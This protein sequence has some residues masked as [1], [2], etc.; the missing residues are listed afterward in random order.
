[1]KVHIQNGVQGKYNQDLA[2]FFVPE[3]NEKPAIKQID[4][5]IGDIASTLFKQGLI[6]TKHSA[7]FVAP[8]FGKTAS[9]LV[10]FVGLGKAE[11]YTLEKVRIIGGTIAKQAKAHKVSSVAIDFDAVCAEL[12]QIKAAR[13]LTE[14]LLLGN[15]EYKEYKSEPEDDKPVELAECLLITNKKMTDALEHAVVQGSLEAEATCFARD[16]VNHPPA[17]IHPKTLKEAAEKIATESRGAITTKSYGRE[18]LTK[19]G[20]GAILGVAQGSEHE[21]FLV[22][23]EYHPKGAKKS[24]ALVG[25]GVTFDS[26]GLS[27]KPS[28]GM[29]DMKMDMAGAAAVLGVFEALKKWKPA[30]HVHG[31]FAT[32]ENM[33]SDHALRVGDIIKTMS[34]KTV[35]VLNTDAEG[36]LILADALHYADSLKTEYII[37]FATLTGACMVAL[38]HQIAGLLTKNEQLRDDLLRISKITGEKLCELPLTEEYEDEIK[39]DVADLQNMPKGRYGGAIIAGLF[40]QHFVKH[41]PWAHIDIA[42]PAFSRTACNAY[43]PAGAS[44]FGVRT[45]LH[46][47][48]QL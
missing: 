3:G 11:D 44:G 32:V 28:E 45:T 16:L 30:V 21:P 26:G 12:D 23:M 25:K 7:M 10:G 34:G 47:L 14:G 9:N 42:G 4:A 41:T 38:G 31:V 17:H 22:H 2:V 18:A 40:L 39:S 19:M 36:R 8:T 15:Y 24:V 29:E 27:L 5:I 1:M 35:E 43:T 13:A 37:D 33:P 46:W 20:A 48:E 6:K